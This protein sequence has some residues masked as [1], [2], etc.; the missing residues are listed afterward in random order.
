MPFQ[1]EYDLELNRKDIENFLILLTVIR[2]PQYDK[3]IR[4]CDQGKLEGVLL[5]FSVFRTNRAI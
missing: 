2:T 4:S 5:E 1:P 3:Q